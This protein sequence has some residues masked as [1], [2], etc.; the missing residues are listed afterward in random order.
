[1]AGGQ[2]YPYLHRYSPPLARPGDGEPE[3]IRA[4][5][6]AERPPHKKPPFDNWPG[7]TTCPG[8]GGLTYLTGRS[9]VP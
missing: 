9:L 3:Q 4:L 8:S 5:G 1:M 2:P 6:E 7:G